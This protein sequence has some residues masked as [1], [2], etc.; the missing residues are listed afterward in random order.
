MYIDLIANNTS[1]YIYITR[2][3]FCISFIAWKFCMQYNADSA[4]MVSRQ[5]RQVVF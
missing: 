3:L 2:I 5:L 4:K 1:E